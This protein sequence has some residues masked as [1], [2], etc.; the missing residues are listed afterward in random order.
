[1]FGFVLMDE[2]E[3]LLILIQMCNM[4]Q[5]SS[6]L[7]AFILDVDIFRLSGRQ[8]KNLCQTIVEDVRVNGI[9]RDDLFFM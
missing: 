6:I 2:S 7:S 9:C 5:H 3:K 4:H 1:M 8:K